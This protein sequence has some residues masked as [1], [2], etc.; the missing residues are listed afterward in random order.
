MFPDWLSAEE[1][2]RLEAHFALLTR[3]NRRLNLTRISDRAEAIERHYNEGLFVA[4]HLPAGP[5]RVVDIGSGAGFPGFPVAVTRPDLE[6]TLVESHQRKA[7]FLKEASRGMGNIRVL[8]RRAEEVP[9]VFDWAVS[10]AVSYE[11]LGGVLGKLA[12]NAALLTG[13]EA[14]PE[15]MGF[16]WEPAIPL[17]ASKQRFLRMG[18][19]R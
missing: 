5:L 9:D 3:W 10:R 7:A 8:A 12:A 18:H 1:A 4:R 2:A 15:G 14:P 11:D 13:A 17:P 19:R 16:A 6:V